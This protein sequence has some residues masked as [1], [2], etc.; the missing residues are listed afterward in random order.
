MDKTINDFL[1]TE[2]REYAKYVVESRAIPNIIDGFKP[3]HRKIFYTALKHCK[4]SFLKTLGLVGY[5][6]AESNYSHGD[7]SVSSAINLL[8]QDFPGANNI[9]MFEGK[10]NFG[11]R[12]IP[13]SAAS[14]YTAIK[15]N[16]EFLNYFSNFD[17]LDT[18]I[19]PDNPEPL[20]YL[21]IIPWVLVNGID[22]IAIGFATS[23]LP[24]D[25]ELLKDVI[26]DKLGVAK[27]FRYEYYTPHFKD[28]KGSIK[29]NK[30]N[31]NWVMLGTYEKCKNNIV[32]VTELPIGMTREKYINHLENM[33]DKKKIKDYTDYS[34]NGFN[35]EIQFYRETFEDD[36]IIQI[37][38]LQT[39]FT[40]NI[41]VIDLEKRVRHFDNPDDLINYYIEYMLKKFDQR[42]KKDIQK[43]NMEDSMIDEI[44]K[45]S[46]LISKNEIRIK[47]ISKSGEIG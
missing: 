3:V 29:Y 41:T 38:K 11:N 2:Y 42:L 5:V 22:G 21:P 1:N 44:I 45:F 6:L 9:P 14:R 26:K 37:L 18:N 36:K 40:E 19:D 12:L 27:T 13:E 20:S 23:I 24:R 39:T 35:L 46:I 8:T 33:I 32:K 17:I 16:N 25:P 28:F 30:E 47:D 10:G 34:K 4:G 43:L 15:L 7:A 31:N